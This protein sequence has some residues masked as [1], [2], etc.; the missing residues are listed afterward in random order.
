[1]AT[2]IYN[3]GIFDDADD[4]DDDDSQILKCLNKS[5]TFGFWN[6]ELS[7]ALFR[8]PGQKLSV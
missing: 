3:Q 7:A 1:M 6:L 4:D 5:M 2:I 8:I